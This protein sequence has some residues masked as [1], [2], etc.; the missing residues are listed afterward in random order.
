MDPLSLPTPA[1]FPAFPYDPPYTVQTDL[2]KHVYSAIE[3]KKIAIVESPT[4]T[5]FAA[6]ITS[7]SSLTVS[8]E[9]RSVFYVQV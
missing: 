2:M 5:V 9:K 6:H 7:P 3:G 4:G 1:S 8:R